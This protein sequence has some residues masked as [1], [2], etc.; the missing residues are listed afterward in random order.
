MIENIDLILDKINT[1]DRIAQIVSDEFQ[2]TKKQS[3]ELL[4]ELITKFSPQEITEKNITDKNV[5]DKFINFIIEKTHAELTEAETIY[6]NLIDN[7]QKGEKNSK[8]FN[9]YNTTKQKIEQI[10]K[11]IP[12]GNKIAFLWNFYNTMLILSGKEKD[13][14]YSKFKS[15]SEE[16]RIKKCAAISDEFIN[17][18][19]GKTYFNSYSDPG[20]LSQFS[21][22]GQQLLSAV[23]IYCAKTNSPDFIIQSLSNKDIGRIAGSSKLKGIFGNIL[24]FCE[25]ILLGGIINIL[26]FKILHTMFYCTGLLTSFSI[27][28]KFAKALISPLKFYSD[29][30]TIAYIKAMKAEKKVKTAAVA[31]PEPNPIPDIT[32]TEDAYMVA[33]TPDEHT[34]DE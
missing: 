10:L 23:A 1:E 3:R 8:N 16:D 12:E 25:G 24:S 32:I 30:D 2:N 29:P 27:I 31:T 13:N 28:G 20:K 21:P 18:N 14:N 15:K 26:P 7:I 17:N 9:L 33:A 22:I 19:L 6:D 11:Q 4:N 5:K 34:I